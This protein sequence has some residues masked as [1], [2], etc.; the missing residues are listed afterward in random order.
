[1]TK[2]KLKMTYKTNRTEARFTKPVNLL[3]YFVFE[4]VSFYTALALAVLE[5]SM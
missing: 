2:T 3:S 1:M 5:C 4:I